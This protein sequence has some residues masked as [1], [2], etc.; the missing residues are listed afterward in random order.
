MLTALQRA[1]HGPG[2]SLYVLP[3][4]F[5]HF[6]LQLPFL[7]W[8]LLNVRV[9]SRVPPLGALPAGRVILRQRIPLLITS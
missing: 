3:G 5:T 2:L 4:Y 8:Q 7:W 6:C 9:Q 1:V